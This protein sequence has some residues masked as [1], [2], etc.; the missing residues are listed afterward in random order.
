MTSR[1]IEDPVSEFKRSWPLDMIAPLDAGSAGARSA[2]LEHWPDLAVAD[3]PDLVQQAAL[4]G[5][6]TWRDILDALVE[7]RTISAACDLFAKKVEL[8]L[9]NRYGERRARISLARA[10]LA[11]EGVSTLESLGAEWGITRERVRQLARS[12]FPEAK[13]A[14]KW[15]APLTLAV[16]ARYTLSPGV[17]VSVDTFAPPGTAHGHGVRLALSI[18]SPRTT[19]PDDLWTETNGEARAVDELVAALPRLVPGAASFSE[20]RH[21][22]SSALPQL[23]EVLD[24]DNTLRFLADHLDFGAGIDGRLGIGQRAVESRVAKKIVTYLQ[25]RAAPIEPGELARA[26]QQGV[27]PFEPF[28]RPQVQPEWLLH[29]ARHSSALLAVHP[30]GRIG[31]ARRLSHLRPTGAI[32]ILQSIVVAHGEPMRM[33]DLCDRA[34]AFGM[35][36][37]QVGVLVHS[38]RAACLFMLDR[39]I[40][41]LAGRDEGAAAGDFEAAHPGASVRVRVGHEIGFD[42]DG[43]IAVNI[44][45]RRSIREQGLALPWPLSVLY[46]SDVAVVLV[47]GRERPM[48]LRTN[49]ALEMPDLEPGSRVQLRLT[50]LQSGMIL[51]VDRDTGRS[52]KPVS[53]RSG[54]SIHPLGLPPVSGRPGWIDSVL[55]TAGT[56]PRTLEQ[57]VRLMP[58][59]MMEKGRAR[60]LYGLVALGLIRPT[61]SGWVPDPGCPMPLKL[62][63]AFAMVDED[64][65]CYAALP[66]D[67]QAAVLWLVWATWLVPSLGWVRIRPN[68]LTDSGGDDDDTLQTTSAPTR[69]RETALMRIVEA[70]HQADDLRRHPGPETGIGATTRVV[71]RYLAGLGYTAYNAVREVARPDGTRGLSAHRATD[72]GPTA[73]WLLRPVGGGLSDS[74]LAEARRLADQ[75]GAPTAVATD[76]LEVMAVGPHERMK[77]DVRAVGREPDQFDRLITLAVDPTALNAGAGDEWTDRKDV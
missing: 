47:D 40:V 37:N 56:D 15:P 22:C 45:V 32:A 63:T 39:G 7:P 41:G 61:G 71:R 58:S 8:L 67:Q 33:I 10:G 21:R 64:P 52:I 43:S 51:H 27:P 50:R 77:V 68:D 3:L 65:G 17:P 34:A 66:R 55:A 31:L 48:V 42:E 5:S 14:L 26:I 4:T 23:D 46:F 59:R 11:G 6:L 12:I 25:R 75:E 62:S 19:V 28:L 38:G 54:G 73:V 76:G 20:L 24:L 44:E 1:F 49:G 16:A 70:A 13:A 29:C 57:L 53:A 18:I 69:P 35:S 30:D 2:L 60:A 72:V 9:Q 36:R 74:D